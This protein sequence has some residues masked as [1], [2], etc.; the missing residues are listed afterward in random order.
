[1]AEITYS[2]SLID[3]L[4]KNTPSTKLKAFPIAKC[5]I[6][7]EEVSILY[8]KPDGEKFI[9]LRPTVD[10]DARFIRFERIQ[11]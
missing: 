6:E 4:Q 2:K 10:N 3:S 5:L 7:D 1:M 8:E 9:R 11:K